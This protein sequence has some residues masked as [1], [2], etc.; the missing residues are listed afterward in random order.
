MYSSDTQSKYHLLFQRGLL[1]NVALDGIHFS[2][3]GLNNVASHTL[4]SYLLLV[5]TSTRLL[6]DLWEQEAALIGT[7]DCGGSLSPKT[8]AT[9]VSAVLTRLP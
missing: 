4:I 5:F 2:F 3:H 6:V 1:L 9:K 8:G 7:S